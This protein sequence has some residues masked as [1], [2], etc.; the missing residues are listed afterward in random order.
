MRG[1]AAVVA[2]VAFILIAIASAAL[3]VRM[4][5]R[6]IDETATAQAAEAPEIASLYIAKFGSLRAAAPWIVQHLKRSGL[7]IALI[8]HRS[9]WRFTSR[10]TAA[11]PDEPQGFAPDR[12]RAPPEFAGEPWHDPFAPNGPGPNAL[13]PPGGPA[14]GGHLL[15]RQDWVAVG[16]AALAGE[17]EHHVA[18]PGG[19]LAIFPDAQPIFAV[20]RT[21]GIALAAVLACCGAMLWLLVRSVRR[22]ALRPL[23]ETTL[24]LRR[25]ALRDF[26]PRTITAG[27]G[28]AYNDLARAYN[29]A[30]DA[31]ST[32]F[33][34]RRAAE[35]EM[36][37]FI[38]DAG[39]ELRTPLTIVMGYLDIIAGGALADP[40]MA[41][42][43]TGGMR[44][45]ASRMHKLIDKLIILARME[46]PTDR[47]L[48]S[49]VDVVSLVQ[50]VIETLEP[51][52]AEPIAVAGVPFAHVYA[53][54]D[55]LA[56]AFTNIVENGLKY[57]PLSPIVVRIERAGERVTVAV[58]DR[59]P[60]MSTDEQRQAFERFYRGDKRGEV[61]GSGLGLAIAKR[62]IERSGGSIRLESMPGV[63][64]TFTVELPQM[65]IAL[66]ES[67]AARFARR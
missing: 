16:V 67:E 51:L 21:V 45:E 47:D 7:H 44:T 10:G 2:I 34:E 18:I 36:Q 17:V 5:A 46:T 33:A 60:G 24:A 20:L 6:A 63:G 22:A 25:L 41:N 12:R 49:N 8:D 57:A 11:R 35:I 61:S 27:D 19:E 52:A 50:R 48:R 13:P 23:H 14:P 42:R 54:E 38:A 56:E 55:E 39:H 32:S 37:R 4:T 40:A 28:S 1:R 53:N 9:G 43:I 59:G 62:A 30:V 66:G 3:A 58:G 31:V 29:A 65:P 64:T 26:S 15:R